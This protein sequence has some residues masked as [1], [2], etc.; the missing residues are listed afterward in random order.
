MA[1]ARFYRPALDSS[2]NVLNGGS[3]MVYD[4]IT[5]FPIGDFLYA[6]AA[7]TVVRSQPWTSPDG[8]I[9]F[10]L[11][12]PK[13]VTIGYTPVGASEILF[14]YQAVYSPGFY[15]I[16]PI[17]TNLGSLST[18]VGDLPIYVEDNMFIESVRVTAGGRPVGSNL[19]IDVKVDGV[20]IWTDTARRPAVTPGA[21]RG[22]VVT[23]PDLPVILSGSSFTMDIAQVGSTT[24]GSDLVVQ[25]WARQQSPDGSV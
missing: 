16:V 10:Y 8:V 7:G 24:P 11:D 2:G 25:I 22:T 3:V 18:F 20:S 4:P 9:D 1:R 6:D 15:V 21:G 14:P 19:V 12:R 13:F 23:P 5:G 17:F